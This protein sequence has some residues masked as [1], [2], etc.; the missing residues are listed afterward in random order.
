LAE[1]AIC[2]KEVDPNRYI[3]CQRCGRVLHPSASCS[4]NGLC[5]DADDDEQGST[6]QKAQSFDQEL[7][8]RRL[9]KRD[10]RCNVC[11]GPAV[12][13]EGSVTCTRCSHTEPA[14]STR[15]PS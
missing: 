7:A 11:G 12:E 4:K 8:L 9:R 14:V 3:L 2:G 6:C 13:G 5:T 10:I 1:C 15:R